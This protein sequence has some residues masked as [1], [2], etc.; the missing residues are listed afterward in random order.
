[1]CGVDSV[2]DSVK[3]SDIGNVVPN[4]APYEFV[5]IPLAYG[6]GAA[7]LREDVCPVMVVPRLIP[8]ALKRHL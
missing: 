8:Q 1:M 6:G 5:L 2:K 3:D 7:S 4:A